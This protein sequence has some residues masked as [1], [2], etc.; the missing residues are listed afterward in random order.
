MRC[1]PRAGLWCLL[2]LGGARADGALGPAM[3]PPGMWRAFAC[4]VPFAGPDGRPLLM[5]YGGINATDAADPLGAAARGLG[6]VHVYDADGETWHAPATA[7]GSSSGPVLPGCGAASGSA[8]AYDPHYGAAGQA[9]TS[10]RVLDTVHWS[11]SAPTQSGQLPVTRFGAAFAYVPSKRAFYMHGG[12]PLSADTN[13]AGSPP[14]IVN[15]MDYLDPSVLTWSYTSNGPARK[16]HTLCYMSAIDSLVLFGGSDQNIGSYNDVKVFSV[17]RSA[18]RYAV[19]VQGDAPAERVLHSA[20]CTEDAMYVFGGM[21][22]VGDAPS[23]STVWVLSAANETSFAWS[24]A[25]IAGSSLSAG[26]AARA[27]HS[28]ALSGGKMYIFGGVG[29]SARDSAMYRLDLGSWEWSAGDSGG[30]S[31]G[32]RGSTRVLVAAVVS[33]VL[34]LVCVGIAGLV[35]Y[36]WNRR[37]GDVR[38]TQRPAPPGSEGPGGCAESSGAASLPIGADG[39]AAHAAVRGAGLRGKARA[40]DYLDCYEDPGF[41]LAGSGSTAVGRRRNSDIVAN[42]YLPSP[43][44]NLSL[45]SSVGAPS[46]AESSAHNWPAGGNTGTVTAVGSEAAGRADQPPTPQSPGGHMQLVS[47]ILAS[48]Q[49][50][51]AWL[52]EAAGRGPEAPAQAPADRSEDTSVSGGSADDAQSAQ[53]YAP[54]RYVDADGPARQGMRWRRSSDASDIDFG[55]H[56]LSDAVPFGPA[57]LEELARPMAPPVPLHMASLYGELESS[58]IVVGQAGALGALAPATGR[59]PPPESGRSSEISI[60]SPLDRLARYH[61]L[62]AAPADASLPTRASSET[63]DTSRIYPARPVRRSAD[64]A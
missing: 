39:A 2:A 42:D 11:W 46:P 8:W 15:N 10:V 31:G 56:T 30:G 37:R 14:G 45:G 43:H 16:Y 13:T 26:P 41:L 22:A 28:A 25:P 33:S 52:R 60:L 32:G 55:E 23:D 12:V 40:G 24:R 36:R 9:A 44:A 54:I 34:G 6:A 48:A 38:Q 64:D 7:G 4:M 51:P 29:A 49:P 47:S 18:W 1:R 35:Y 62:G 20:V 21:H 3:D 59:A 61:G 58:G 57:P 17:E 63:D 50:I 27:G 53:V 5:L 19:D